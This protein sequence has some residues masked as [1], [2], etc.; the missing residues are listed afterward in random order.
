MKTDGSVHPG[1]S[2]HNIQV[3]GGIVG[4]VFA[5]GSIL[6]FLLGVPALRWFCMGSIA[7]GLGVAVALPLFHK[8]SSRKEARQATLLK[9]N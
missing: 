8:Y 6:V 5:F 3:G 2:I 7:L 4:F 9:L 1:I